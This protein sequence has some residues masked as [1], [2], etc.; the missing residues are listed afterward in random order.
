M[1][2]AIFKIGGLRFVAYK[3][4]VL[5]AGDAEVAAVDGYADEF[6][7]VAENVLE[8]AAARR[9]AQIFTDVR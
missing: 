5:G 6:A 8:T 3:M 4:V 9:S 7:R 2:G 1:I